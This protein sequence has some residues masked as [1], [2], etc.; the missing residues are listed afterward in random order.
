MAATTPEW[1]ALPSS[2]SRREKV[3]VTVKAYPNPSKKYIETVCVAGI[4][5]ANQWI[6]LYP[7]PYRFMAYDQQFPNYS[8]IE[9]DVRKS[10]DHRPESH[11]ADLG[12]IRTV[13]TMDTSRGWEERKSF[14]LPLASPS[15]EYLID[16]NAQFNTSLGLIRPKEVKRLLI[17]KEPPDWSPEELAKLRQR[18]LMEGLGEDGTYKVAQ[19]LEKIPFRFQYEF[20]CDDP[21]CSGH[22]YTVISWE[23]MQS[24][25][26][27]RA[28][29]GE[30][31]W[32]A[33][34]RQKYE[35]E[36]LSPQ[37][38]LHFYVGTVLSHPKTWT[39]IGLFYPPSGTVGSQVIQPTLL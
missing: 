3:L 24:Y 31:G 13:G 4:T 37:R 2:T 35:N 14:L 33:A 32:E 22:K 12:S 19:D 38:D 15:M 36:F 28:K 29:Y 26:K 6:R 1:A 30:D 23:V 20:V 16:Q 10:K 27:W 39:I 17:K 9:V 5:E 7:I 11:Y 21:L 34:F 8:W 18:S 25:R